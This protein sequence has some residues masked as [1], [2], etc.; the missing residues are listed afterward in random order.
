MSHEIRTPM[1]AIIGMTDLAARHAASTP[2]SASTPSTVQRSGRRS[3]RRSSTTSSISPRSRRASSTIE[4]IDFQL[5][6]RLIEL[7][8][9]LAAQQAQRQ[10]PRTRRI[11][12]ARTFPIACSAIRA[13]C[14]RCS[15]T[16]SATPSS[17]PSSGE[18]VVSVARLERHER[19]LPRCSS[20]CATPASASPPTSS[21]ELFQRVRPGR[22]LD[23]A[24]IRRHRPRPGD[25]Y[26]T[27]RSDGRPRSGSKASPEKA[28]RFIFTLRL[29][30]DRDAGTAPRPEGRTRLSGQ[31]VLVVDDNQ[32]AARHLALQ[33]E[34]WG[35]LAGVAFDGDGAVSAIRRAKARRNRS[36]W[37]SWTRAC[38]LPT[39]SR[40]RS[41]AAPARR[42][43]NT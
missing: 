21:G 39:A 29:G 6:R 2:S 17:S 13:G 25:L 43:P 4:H 22:H 15:P 36:P 42:A 3:A 37:C 41:H 5:R 40:W 27:G 34:E 35:M 7:G 20:R 9:A 32:T 38:R 10:G 19:R 18:I 28:A 12:R 23:H 16:W 30:A 24:Q 8:Q 33:L 31:R 1:N 14:A 26:P 11:R